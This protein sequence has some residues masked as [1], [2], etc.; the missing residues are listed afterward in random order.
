LAKEAFLQSTLH[1][2][3][4]E[5]ELAKQFTVTCFLSVLALRQL[6]VL[7]KVDAEFVGKSVL[8][9]ERQMQSR[10]AL[11]SLVWLFQGFDNHA[12]ESFDVGGHLL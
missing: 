5:L 10:V 3:V 7:L 8:G 12:V 4:L 9:I 6:E 1:G 11:R 2:G